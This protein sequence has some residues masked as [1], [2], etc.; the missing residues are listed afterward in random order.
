MLIRTAFTLLKPKILTVK[1]SIFKNGSLAQQCLII[2]GTILVLAWLPTAIFFSVRDSLNTFSNGSNPVGFLELIVTTFVSILAIAACIHALQ[3]FFVSREN[4]LFLLAPLSKAEFFL[5]RYIE[6]CFAASWIL[7]LLFMPML[8]GYASHIKADWNF[9][10]LA[11]FYFIFLVLIESALSIATVILL[12]KIYPARRLKELFIIIA[13][14]F[15]IFLHFYSKSTEFVFPKI[16]NGNVEQFEETL[17]NWHQQISQRSKKL[18]SLPLLELE[19]NNASNSISLF[20]AL[21]ALFGLSF[22]ASFRVFSDFY[23][24]SGSLERWQQAKKPKRRFWL[25]KPRSIFLGFFQKDIHLFLRDLAQPVQLILFI[26]IAG[27]TLLSF[28]QSTL[29]KG[30]LGG[31]ALIFNDII[32]AVGI[33][34]HVLLTVLFAGRF[35][36]P[37]LALEEESRWLIQGSPL[38]GMQFVKAKYQSQTV[39]T[40]IVLVPL[41]IVIGFLSDLTIER[42]YTGAAL[43]TL[44][45]LGIDAIALGSGGLLARIFHN[46]L[47]NMTSTLGSFVFMTVSLL[48][49]PLCLVFSISVASFYSLLLTESLSFNGIV[50]CVVYGALIRL[51]GGFFLRRAAR[52]W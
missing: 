10:I 4:E 8:Y 22:A 43:S 48:V 12:A 2:L 25:Q 34:S 46:N 19:K 18:F 28:R 39:L 6:N 52:L 44:S 42:I 23:E 50:C 15:I 49:I 13:L 20:C 38:S 31:D 3:I 24:H 41:Y 45:I 47:A 29:L 11:T 26:A 1:N 40:L 5:G 30:A 51:V 9:Y 14:V 33:L 35:I 21:S 16:H 17:K 27:V 32:F 37:A 36:F 7:F